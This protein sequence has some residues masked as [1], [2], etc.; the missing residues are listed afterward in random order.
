MEQTL[1]VYVDLMGMAVKVGQLWSRLRSGRESMSFEYERNWLNN[2]KRFSLDPALRLAE[3]SFH[4]SPEKA[5]FGAMDD[6]APDRWGRML[7]RRSER[8]NAIREKRVVR[9]LGEVDFLL[10]VDDECRQGALRFKREEKGPFLTSYE[11]NHIP[12]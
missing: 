12:P 10:M 6:S 3:G 9:T 8:K 5:V 7:M 11:K 2:P 4:A 1:L